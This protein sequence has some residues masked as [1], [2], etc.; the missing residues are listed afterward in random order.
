L[1]K[2]NVE[3]EF[4]VE[5]EESGKFK[6]V[7]V[8]APGGGPLKPPPKREPRVKAEPTEGDETG[9][10]KENN[11]DENAEKTGRGNRRGGGRGGR[12][13]KST[14]EKK[15]DPPFHDI[16]NDEVKQMI[17]E[18]G[19]ELVKKN[20]ID[21][22]LGGARIKLGRGGY[23]G[24]CSSD[25][26]VAEGTYIC[27]EQGVVTFDWKLSVEYIGDGWQAADVSKIMPTLSLVAG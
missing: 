10:L 27:D 6:A 12:G 11:G 17:E 20:T 4:D 21:V 14:G 18:K 24:Y 1:Q 22:A 16:I 15:V 25:A 8:T 9:E 3:V 23:C 19:I 26:V 5:K 13:K 7:N 2:E